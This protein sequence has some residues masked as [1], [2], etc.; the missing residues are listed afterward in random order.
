M[1]NGELFWFHIA[2]AYSLNLHSVNY[3][4]ESLLYSPMSTSLLVNIWLPSLK[5][6]QTRQNPLQVSCMRHC[7]ATCLQ[8]G[9]CSSTVKVLVTQESPTLFFLSQSLRYKGKGE[10]CGRSV[11]KKHGSIC[12]HMLNLKVVVRKTVFVYYIA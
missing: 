2:F 11:Y 1:L 6:Q 3:C 5:L 12:L 4:N 9:M 10:A 7:F 8:F